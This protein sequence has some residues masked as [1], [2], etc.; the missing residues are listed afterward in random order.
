M[1]KGAKEFRLKKSTSTIDE[2]TQ[3]MKLPEVHVP[4]AN[5]AKTPIEKSSSFHPQSRK[6]VQTQNTKVTPQFDKVKFEK[7][8]NKGRN[9]LPPQIFNFFMNN[10]IN[11][12]SANF[13]A[14]LQEGKFSNQPQNGKSNVEQPKAKHIDKVQ[15]QKELI[16]SEVDHLKPEARPKMHSRVNSDQPKNLVHKQNSCQDS[17]N[18]S[19]GSSRHTSPNNSLNVSKKA[20]GKGKQK[21]SFFHSNSSNLHQRHS[22]SQYKFE[23]KHKLSSKE[24][25]VLFV[26]SPT[27]KKVRGTKSKFKGKH[28]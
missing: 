9:N 15:S 3:S 11:Q 2:K 23:K 19:Q 1:R 6:P 25:D 12:L 13:M 24:A 27:P 22:S 10:D 17:R 20:S 8:F 7:D 28:L 4:K 5:E 18:S 26:N 14:A 16:P 21:W